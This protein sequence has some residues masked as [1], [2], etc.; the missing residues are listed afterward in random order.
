MT[1]EH[2]AVTEFGD[3]GHEVTAVC[4]GSDL[5]LEALPPQA[6]ASGLPA[7]VGTTASVGTIGA[8]GHQSTCL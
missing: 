4:D 5:D 7:S 8:C 2:D 1:H 6:P 3:P